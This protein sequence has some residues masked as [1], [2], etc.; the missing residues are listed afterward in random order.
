MKYAAIAGFGVVGGGVAEIL[1][2]NAAVVEKNAGQAIDLKAIYTRHPKT[3]G[4]FASY[5]V[6]DFS[7]VENDPEID[8][9][10][11]TIG[12]C[13]AAFDIVSRSLKAGKHVVTAN[14]QLIAEHGLALF[15][16]A[17]ANGVNLLFEASVA[18]GIPVL[19]PL[20]RC[21]GANE[22]TEVSGILNGTTNYI[23]TQMLENGESYLDALSNAQRLG[24]AEADPT[25]DVE[26]IDAAR[27]SCILS[28]LAFGKN[29]SPD[30]IHVEGISKVDAADAAFA[31]AG[32]MKIKLLGRTLLQNGKRFCFV[33]P[34]FIQNSAMLAGVNGVFNAVCVRGSEV[35]EVLFAGPGAGRYPTASAVVGDLI[36]IVKNPGRVQPIGW[37]ACTEKPADFSQ[38]CA[39][40]YIRVKQADRQAAEQKLGA[41]TWLPD[42]SGYSAGFTGPMAFGRIQ[43]AGIAL[44][45]AWP[46]FE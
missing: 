43:D 4:P 35:G 12:G 8:L 13:G 17:R 5:F 41:L 7:A 28:G 15:E 10:V 25:A 19:N 46:I 45:S 24:Y 11:E 2:K 44:L 14:K 6:P 21:L 30:D 1:L 27:K 22:I 16:L 36:D 32:G 26:G 31:E 33:S 37:E 23:L 9:V 42:R 3:D 39:R 38:F 34:H 40:F 18:G 20:T 29:V